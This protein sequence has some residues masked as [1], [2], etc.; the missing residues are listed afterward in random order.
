MFTPEFYIDL[1]VTSKKIVTNEIYKDPVLNKACHAF[2]DAQS[3]FAKMLA[4]NTI[5]ISAHS[6]DSISKVFFP[7]EKTATA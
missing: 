1:L 5:D 3:V 4:K 6:V 7:K 2:I